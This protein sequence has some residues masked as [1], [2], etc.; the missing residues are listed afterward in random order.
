M[1]KFWYGICKNRHTRTRASV[2]STLPAAVVDAA[3]AMLKEGRGPPSPSSSAP[4]HKKNT[5]THTIT[6]LVKT[7]GA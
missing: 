2:S 7:L 6:T 5:H 1:I 3:K 4:E